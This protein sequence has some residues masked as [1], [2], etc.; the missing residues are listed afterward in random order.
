[1][2]DG[3][4]A[5]APARRP[6]PFGPAPAGGYEPLE[7]GPDTCAFLRGGKVLVVAKL[8]PGAGG[9]LCSTPGGEWRDIMHGRQR[10]L[11]GRVAVAELVGEDGVA[12]YE[13]L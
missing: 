7:A 6:Q 9:A 3:A 2:A 11:G 4:S 5:R 8:R 13:R 12:V 1:M 10:S